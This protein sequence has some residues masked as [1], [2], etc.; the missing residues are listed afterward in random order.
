MFLAV[1]MNVSP[2][3]RLLVEA[4]KSI[5]SAPSRRAA[6]AET[7]P[8]PRR[9]LEE[10]VDASLAGQ[11]RHLPLPRRDRLL[12]LGGRVEDEDDFLGR[13]LLEA[14]QVPPR[15][16]RR[17]RRQFDHFRNHVPRSLCRGRFSFWEDSREN[18]RR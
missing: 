10:Q 17:R 4:E 3:E 18:G 2:F 7:G 12:E 9:I 11:Q 15:P 8:R 5:V 13:K 6:S 1:S 14:E 16:P